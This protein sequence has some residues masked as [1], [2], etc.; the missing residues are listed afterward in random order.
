RNPSRVRQKILL[1][2]P[3]KPQLHPWRS[4]GFFSSCWSPP[5]RSC[6]SPPPRSPA[7]SRR[8]RSASR[9]VPSPLGLSALVPSMDS[10]C[11]RSKLC[12]FLLRVSSGGSIQPEENRLDA[13][14]PW[15]SS[16]LRPSMR[17]L[18]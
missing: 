1:S 12:V 15:I 11:A 13:V 3:N 7:T 14:R 9:Y 18:C 10:A 8:S 2:P 5:P 6:S 17:E 4:R 16:D